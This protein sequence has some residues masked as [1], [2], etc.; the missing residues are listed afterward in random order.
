[1]NEEII[2]KVSVV[3][4]AYNTEKYIAVAIES[5]LNQTF[6]DFE[7]IIIDDGST[8]KTGEIIQ[9]YAKKDERIIFLRNT[10]NLHNYKTRNKG[11]MIAKG[12]YIVTMDAD[13]WSYPDRLQK[14]FEFMERNEEV[15]LC[16][17]FIEICGLN[18]KVINIR[19]YPETDEK[20]RKKI[21]KYNPF[22]HPATM[23]RAETVKKVGGY[24]DKYPLSQDYKLEFKVGKFGK[25]A[26]LPEVLHKLRTHNDSVSMLHTKKQELYT[27]QIRI[28][29]VWKYEYHMT[30]FDKG[31]FVL[32]FISIFLLPNRARFW[33]FNY[34]RRFFIIFGFAI[35]VF[36]IFD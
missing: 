29:A 6:K 9:G 27:L 13:D 33:L 18:L 30:I 12:K 7:F 11:V 3:M 14:Q 32:Q 25:F 24:N 2:P 21:F 26:N 23:W 15:V 20:I 35:S 28:K 22:C 5:I 4:P 19:N 1:M 31:Y 36:E 10:E 16:G 17:S 34:L 8:D